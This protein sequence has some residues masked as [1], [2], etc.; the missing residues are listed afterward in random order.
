M[1][2]ATINP[3]KP[4]RPWVRVK[5]APSGRFY[6]FRH[7]TTAGTE[8]TWALPD[9]AVLLE[10]TETWDPKRPRKQRAAHSDP[11]SEN[12]ELQGTHVPEP[13]ENFA[14][15]LREGWYGDFVGKRQ[16]SSPYWRYV[17]L[18]KHSSKEVED[19]PYMK[20]KYSHVCIYPVKVETRTELCKTLLKQPQKF[21]SSG[22]S[23]SSTRLCDHFM[24]Y[25]PE[26]ELGEKAKKVAQ[27]KQDRK[28][29]VMQPWKQDKVARMYGSL[30]VQKRKNDD[31]HIG[32]ALKRQAASQLRKNSILAAQCGWYV[33][34]ESKVSMREFSDPLFRDML[35]AM[36]IGMSD[37]IPILNRN[38]LSKW[39]IAE[40]DI[41]AKH[42]RKHFL[43]AWNHS[44]QQAIGQIVHDVGKLAN[45]SK[46][47][48]I[49]LQF[50]PVS[51][52][53]NVVIAI[54]FVSSENNA[55]PEVGSL[56]KT[57]MREFLQIGAEEEFDVKDYVNSM[58]SNAA[59]LKVAT[60]S[61]L[62]YEA[63]VC[64]MHQGDKIGS[65][66]VGDLV[67]SKNKVEVNPF[68]ACQGLLT[69]TRRLAT[70]YSFG[71]PLQK[72]Q[73]HCKVLQIPFRTPELDYNSTR[74]ASQHRLIASML[75]LKKAIQSHA[76][77]DWE[78]AHL[79]DKLSDNDWKSLTELE[80]ILYVTSIGATL[81]QSEVSF[82]GAYRPIVRQ[83]VMNRLFQPS[84]GLLQVNNPNEDCKKAPRVQVETSTFTSIGKEALRRGILEAQRRWC[85]N[86]TETVQPVNNMEMN[87]RE[88]T[89]ALLDIRVVHKS[90]WPSE[91]ARKTAKNEL[92]QYYVDYCLKIMDAE[93]NIAETPTN[94][95]SV[96]P[97]SES[98]NEE[99]QESYND[100]VSDT[101]WSDM[102][103]GPETIESIRT[104]AK[105]RFEQEF[106]DSWKNFLK[107]MPN[108][109]WQRI[110][111]LFFTNKTIS[112]AVNEGS[113]WKNIQTNGS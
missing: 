34:S 61:D 22:Y 96:A 111:E 11:E 5:D 91:Y 82:V 28:E 103:E 38:I 47:Q 84:L 99:S 8:T 66:A 7:G 36:A 74:I 25:H 79:E 106:T 9:G 89:A 6:Y 93:L 97:V 104:Q 55:S 83:E 71:S 32:N 39:V 21:G 16:T 26:S 49:G 19:N 80:A 92:K 86:T 41:V 13:P 62:G 54:G 113:N 48:A 56:I 81:T 98:H 75:Y 50:I 17:K 95:K 27:N 42:L 14:R 87:E 51:W 35:K 53:R 33:F 107:A 15:D 69:R 29:E 4:E 3:E 108:E 45:N 57:C 76:I 31:H 85:G 68:E 112:L 52:E 12:S 30:T 43:D 88:K 18:L 24:V 70:W 40:H 59:A 105:R 37:D 109:K 110:P 60:E 94:E 1:S 58:G 101:V 20:Q 46:Y 90:I 64:L 65:S 67:R 72:L 100:G 2:M 44:G 63:E 77:A 73:Q 102:E 10:E 23:W 78:A